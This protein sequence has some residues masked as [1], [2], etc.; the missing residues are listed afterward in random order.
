M[1]P[2][3]CGLIVKL[4]FLLAEAFVLPIYF[5]LIY[6]FTVEP[7]SA[8]PVIFFALLVTLLIVGAAGG[9]T[10]TTVIAVEAFI[11]PSTDLAVIVAFPL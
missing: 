4:K 8:F 6:T 5:P 2:V 9:V 3:F 7:A 1:L 11:E 10:S